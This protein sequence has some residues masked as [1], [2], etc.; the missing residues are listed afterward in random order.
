MRN[1]S[2]LAV[3]FLCS[4]VFPL[5]GQ[6]QECNYSGLEGQRLE[7]KTR[8]ASRFSEEV[9][10]S[11][12]G[13]GLPKFPGQAFR[14]RQA[15]SSPLPSIESVFISCDSPIKLSGEL[16]ASNADGFFAKVSLTDARYNAQHALTEQVVPL[17]KG[18]VGFDIELTKK[19][20]ENMQSSYLKVSVLRKEDSKKGKDNWFS[21]FKLWSPVSE[22]AH[23][24]VLTLTPVKN[25]KGIRS[26][27][28][29]IPQG[30]TA[31][32][33]IRV[34]SPQDSAHMARGK[35]S[36]G[37]NSNNYISLFNY[38]KSDVDFSDPSRISPIQTGF[39]YLDKNVSSGN[40]YYLPSYY[41]LTWE[42]A[43][44]FDF[45][46]QYNAAKNAGEE[47]SVS[48]SASLSNGITNQEHN[49][50]EKLLSTIGGVE[51]G[52]TLKPVVPTDPKIDFQADGFVLENIVAMSPSNIY[53]P[54]N[55]SWKTGVLEANDIITALNNNAGLSGQVNYSAENN[56]LNVDANI[57]ILDPSTFGSME[58]NFKT[59]R[60]NG[61]KNKTP[62]PVKI[63][64]LHLLVL[65]KDAKGKTLP[66]IY[67]WSIEGN[68]IKP[69]N[70]ATFDL[71]NFPSWMEKD[72]R[73]LKAWFEYDVQACNTCAEVVMNEITS[74]TA[75]SREKWILFNALNVLKRYDIKMLKVN[76]RSKQADPRGK[77][78]KNVS[79][80][81]KADNQ[82]YSVGPLYSWSDDNLDYEVQLVLINDDDEISSKWMSFKENEMYI[83]KGA[84]KKF[85][86][87]MIKHPE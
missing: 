21:I 26:G 18:R 52:V 87:G 36:E 23:A 74:G 11:M 60:S 81:I 15:Q 35:A 32:T 80:T 49:L 16:Y 84:M 27:G 29:L 62:F 37:I 25:A 69:G 14:E 77:S 43:D 82:N 59:W 1:T 56:G 76:L 65:D 75:S 86:G 72:D 63:N 13:S 28:S 34:E 5:L 57:K 24:G 58:P 39:M 7:N 85:F 20:I 47:G 33:S 55:I 64:Y 3:V 73:L 67:S 4:L 17:D 83:T 79:S 42:D 44:G 10:N 54:L 48:M 41:R 46:M 45:T 19:D 71:E 78:I 70:N 2:F 38:I 22:E 68:P 50:I 40:F 31:N 6:N 61:W 30:I 9:R 12:G 66:F 53:S 51:E 8:S